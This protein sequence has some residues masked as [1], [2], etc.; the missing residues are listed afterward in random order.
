VLKDDGHDREFSQENRTHGQE[1][2]W[3]P[4]LGDQQT[5]HEYDEV[6]DDRLEN[7]K[8]EM[9]CDASNNVAVTHIQKPRG[10][11]SEHNDDRPNVDWKSA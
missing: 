6:D 1:G 11:T 2:F 5:D 7:R 3:Q 10:H 9:I 8:Q 4:S